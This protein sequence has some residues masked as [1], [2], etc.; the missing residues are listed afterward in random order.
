MLLRFSHMKALGRGPIT[1][2][3]GAAASHGAAV[4]GAVYSRDDW[5]AGRDL[6]AEER[7]CG[8]VTRL[9]S[10]EARRGSDTPSSSSL[11]VAAAAPL[12]A[13]VRA[14]STDSQVSEV[15]ATGHGAFLEKSPRARWRK[16]SRAKTLLVEDTAT[17]FSD[18]SKSYA[19][20]VQSYGEYVR[21]LGRLPEGQPLL[22]FVLYRDGYSLDSVR[23]R[24]EYE[25]AVP[26]D[27][28]YLHPPP[29][30]SFASITQFGLAVG[31]TREQLPHV[32]RRYNVHAMVLDDRSYHGLAELPVL[33]APPRGHLHRVV[34]RCVDGDEA[35][36]S[37]RLRHLRTAGYVNYFGVETFGIGSNT[38]F[39]L[40][41]CQHRGE[42]DRAVGGFLQTMAESS[43]L[44]HASYLAYVNAE[45]STA[46]GV[47]GEWVR[48]CE[49]AKVPRRTR[50]MLQSLRDYH[51]RHTG[52]ATAHPEASLQPVWDLCGAADRSEASAAAFVWNAMASQRLLSYGAVPV[53]G[54]LVRRVGVDG[55]VEVVEIATD[56]E[57][58]TYD[59]TDVVLPV[60]HRGKA[61]PYPS[62]SVNRELFVQFATMHHL[63][64]LLDT[65]AS[66]SAELSAGEMAASF[67][68]VV[69]RP[70]RLQAAVVRDPTSCASLKSDLFLLQ[71]HQ[72]TESWSLDYE[73][74][75]R[76]PSLFN[77]SERFREKMHYVCQ[78][79]RGE[80]SVVVAFELPAESSPWVALREVFDLRY[81]SFHDFYGV[82]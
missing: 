53:K 70:S 47:V 5:N 32:S 44:H 22:R 60:P 39:D 74:R 18:P 75:V 19:P 48:L 16:I 29:G 69:R 65:A 31:V 81:G 38:L 66:P 17:P 13:V 59:I 40:A 43:P 41:A 12:R 52:A 20:R 72:P 10:S 42:L 77:V 34:L 49:R 30:G 4:A 57:A 46:A 33:S 50:A 55:A 45:D 15:D 8:M 36:V 27:A 61:L 1:R 58:A 64:F 78:H 71:E 51:H 79:Q 24:F 3:A 14:Q 21:R 9:S 82:A 25:I 62:H 68:H 28:L 37:A 11:S 76:E 80:N 67:R 54:D 35:A 7:R 6:T 26:S 23:H 2:L 56:A 73:R 63:S